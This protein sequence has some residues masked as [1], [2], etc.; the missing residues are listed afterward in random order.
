MAGAGGDD[1]ESKPFEPSEKKRRDAREKGDVPRAQ[2]LAVAL[3]YG[4]FLLAFWVFGADAVRR[5]GDLGLFLLQP[6][7]L[8]TDPDAPPLGTLP[9]GALLREVAVAIGPIL[10]L[11]A[12]VVLVGALAE[13]SLVVA[14]DRLKPKLSKISPLSNARQKFGRKGLFEFA[15][16]TV[17]LVLVTAVLGLFALTLF[18]PILES[19]A[20]DPRLLGTQMF[21]MAGK[22]LLA[23]TIVSAAMGVLDALFQ[24]FDWLR[25]NRM[26][27]REL[28]EETKESEG[29]PYIKAQRRQKG[30]ALV[31]KSVQEA[32]ANAAVV[33]VNPEHYAVALDWDRS[34]AGAPVCVAKGV[35]AV[36]LRIREIAAE[37]DVPIHPDPPTARALHATLE[38]GDEVQ[39]D[40][41]RPVAAAIR[42][43][44]ALR[45]RRRAL[46]V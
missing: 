19:A 12:A 43:A 14:P 37:N 7:L 20:T 21:A 28:R 35:D 5:F 10:L 32:V 8:R 36:A 27:Y 2:E 15:K 4:G 3:S 22:F 25:R 13:G 44:E 1:D 38:V 11:P 46:G 26:S 39:P 18:D 40:L 33:I 6:G 23:V 17:K 30:Q 45:A 42:F 24:R 29:D 9:L 34:H 16:S 31:G 41:Y